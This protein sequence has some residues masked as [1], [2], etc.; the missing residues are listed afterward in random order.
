MGRLVDGYVDWHRMLRLDPGTYTI[1][2]Y[3]NHHEPLY[4]WDAMELEAGHRRLVRGPDG[5]AGPPRQQDRARIHRALT[6][7]GPL[8]GWRC[9][10]RIAFSQ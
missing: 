5:R 4:R 8:V 3:V 7:G 1:G 6:S 9:T 2:C 10:A